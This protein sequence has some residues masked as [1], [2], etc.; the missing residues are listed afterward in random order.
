MELLILAVVL[1]AGLLLIPLGLPGTWVMVGAGV[2]F[3]P[4]VGAERIGW[5]TMLATALLA[6]AG[7]GIELV[8][9]GR[10]ARKYGGSRRA[11]WGAII[12]GLAGAFAGIPV[13]IVGPMIGAFGGAFVGALV[14]EYTRGREAG[15]AARVATGALLGRVAGVAVKVAIGCAIAAWLLLAA[16]Q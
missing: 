5:V 8:L 4:L 2:L 13:P 10:Y 16:W 6:L 15:P 12:G 9:A 1:F 11:G 7:E 14:A 3:N